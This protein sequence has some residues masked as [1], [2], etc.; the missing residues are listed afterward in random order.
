MGTAR[1][2]DRHSNVARRFEPYLFTQF[3]ADPARLRVCLSDDVAD[4]LLFSL[5]SLGRFCQAGFAACY[6]MFLQGGFR[7]MSSL[8]KERVARSVPFTSAIFICAVV[9]LCVSQATASLITFDFT[10]S[11]GSQFPASPSFFPPFGQTISGFYTFESTTP[12]APLGPGTV[13]YANTISA[14]G[15]TSGSYT[16]GFVGTPQPSPEQGPPFNNISIVNGSEDRYHVNVSLTGAGI[17]GLNP[18]LFEFVF[19]DPSGTAFS[20]TDLPLVPPNFASFTSHGLDMHFS[21][22]TGGAGAFVSFAVT[23]LTLRPA[24]V[25]APTPLL[26]LFS[27]IAGVV[28]LKRSFTWRRRTSGKS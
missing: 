15:F 18:G 17:A 23:S 27:G 22:P 9:F 2:G 14:F 3:C 8:H 4:N 19:T 10:G 24:A 12:G 28:V 20:T 1:A 26:L 11:L 6:F 16:G 25:S 7:M 13:T 21:D 5:R